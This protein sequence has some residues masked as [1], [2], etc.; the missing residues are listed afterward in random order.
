M[1]IP[2]TRET[3]PVVRGTGWWRVA[4]AVVLLVIAR[5]AFGADHCLVAPEQAGL[6]IPI[7]RLD[8]ASRCMIATVVNDYTTSG[9]VGPV[10]TPIAQDF[11]T[12]L[13]DHPVLLGALVERLGLGHYRFALK[14]EG[15]Y[16]VDDGDGTQGM[17]TVV[18]RDPSVR[19]YHLDGY[20]EGSVFPMVKAKA[21]VFMGMV[22]VTAPDGHP[23]VESRL[24]A[25]TKLTDTVLAALV[26]LLRPLV[27]GAVTRKLSRGFDVTYQLGALIAQDPQRVA[28]EATGLDGIDEAD[29]KALATLLQAVPPPPLPVQPARSTP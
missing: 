14:G 29:R 19:I 1:S 8:L 26:R 24:V 18:Y 9:L 7:G 5:G 16:W 10:Q 12:Y 28:R 13:L 25:Y 6:H 21:V 15:R 20:H 4:L 27:G 11:F 23:S 3:A 22:P 2:P 17:L